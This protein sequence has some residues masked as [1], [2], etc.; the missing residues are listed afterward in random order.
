M[1]AG[2]EALGG[3]VARLADVLEHDV[4]VLAAGRGLSA[5][6]LGIAITQ[7]R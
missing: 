5:A 4:V 1:V 2:L 3:E 7:V 6:G